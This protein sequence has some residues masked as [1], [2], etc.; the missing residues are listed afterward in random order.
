MRNILI[1][2]NILLDYYEEKRRKKYPDSIKAF[3]FLKYKDFAFVSSSSIDN[4]RYGVM[5]NHLPF[6][7]ASCFC[8]P[9]QFYS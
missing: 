4:L 9:C 1:D 2:L 3:D 8:M 5:L 7:S 6:A